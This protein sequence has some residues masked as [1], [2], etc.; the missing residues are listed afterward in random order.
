MDLRFK[1][2]NGRITL[3]VVACSASLAVIL[4]PPLEALENTN[5]TARMIE[6]A[7]LIVY[8]VLLGY[9]I[10]RH[11]SSEHAVIG[12]GVG[13]LLF[14]AI[15]KANRSSRGLIFGLAIPMVLLTY[16]N[17][18]ANFDVTAVNVSVRYVA[19]FSY[20]GAAL[21]AGMAIASMPRALR[22]GLLLFTFLSVGM[23]GSMM[24]VWQP[25]FYTA[26][27]ATQN[28]ESNTFLM[29][30]GAFGEIFSGAWTLKMLSVL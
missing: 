18:P 16:W 15:Q 24:L 25:G 23:M 14:L 5:L 3:L 28:V 2:S 6:D 22:A 26:Y 12:G 9:G 20:L 8:A 29:L 7:L 10:D 1:G 27:S 13:A 21:L 30:F 4:F 19:D 11:L 17:F